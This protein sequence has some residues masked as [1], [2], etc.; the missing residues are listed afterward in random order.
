MLIY[1]TPFEY[2]SIKKNKHTDKNLITCLFQTPF[3][4]TLHACFKFK[5]KPDSWNITSMIILTCL[6]YPFKYTCIRI[7]TH[8][9]NNYMLVFRLNIHNYGNIICTYTILH[10]QCFKIPFEYTNMLVFLCVR[11]R[12]EAYN[13]YLIY[14]HSLLESFHMLV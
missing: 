14:T 2:T 4:Y 5:D 6:K 8:A 3:K 13:I 10:K 1:K 12:H 9:Y 11:N 7:H